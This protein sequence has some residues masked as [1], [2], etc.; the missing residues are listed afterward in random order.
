MSS[1]P[2]DLADPLHLLEPFPYKTLLVAAA[3]LG[4]LL[5]RLIRRLHRRKLAAPQP[6][7]RSVP[8]A[9]AAAAPIAERIE[10]LWRRFRETGRFR[11]G[12]HEL[13]GLLRAQLE[14]ERRRRFSSLTAGEIGRHLGDSP[15]SRLFSLLAGLQFGRR[16]PSR[17]DF[18][19]V[20]E[21]AAEVA[22]QRPAKR[23]RRRR[24]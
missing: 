1:L 19:G 12:C 24:G 16:P 23:K 13:A 15:W 20:C 4:Y 9:A 22:G 6:A 10:A 14:A 8:A 18:Q 7:P 2:G 11:E 21:L 3:V 5:W 17:S